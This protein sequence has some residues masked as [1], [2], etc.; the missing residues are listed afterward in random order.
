MPPIITSTP[1]QI[2]IG[3][4]LID[5]VDIIQK[6]LNIALRDELNRVF[7]KALPAIQS[8]IQ[9][10]SVTFFETAPEAIALINGPLDAHFGIPAGEAKS[11]VWKIIETVVNNIEVSFTRISI[12]GTN[13]GGGFTVGAVIS[14]FSDV[15]NLPEA[16]I[17]TDKGEDLPWLEWL[18]KK[19]NTIIIGDYSIKFGDYTSSHGFWNSRSGKAIM[20]K[21]DGGLWRVPPQYA[22]TVRNNWLT[23]SIADMSEA[24]LDMIG[25]VMQE[26]IE[27]AI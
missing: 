16:H 17:I 10:R 6:K 21:Q 20:I 22:G 24:W 15:L 4:T 12:R 5:P 26:Q 14:D 27:K 11:R 25:D 2:P 18:L 1:V 19:G 7:P 9:N 8:A 3:I 23:H 13:F